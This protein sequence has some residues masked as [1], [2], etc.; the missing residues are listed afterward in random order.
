[1]RGPCP[2]RSSRWPGTTSSTCPNSTRTSCRAGTSALSTWAPT[3][4]PSQRPVVAASPSD[5][6]RPAGR[7]P[8]PRPARAAWRGRALSVGLGLL[9]GLAVVW[10][11]AYFVL[12]VTPAFILGLVRAAAAPPHA[13]ADVTAPPGVRVTAWATGLSNPTSL[14]FGPD[15]RLY[16]AELAG[17]VLALADRDGDGSAETRVTFATG[18]AS[19]LGLAFYG[20]DLY[21]GRRG[22]VTRLSDTN[23]DGVADQSVT[24]IGGLP[25]LRHQTDGLAFGP[26]GRLYIGQ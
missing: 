4:S 12:G 2:R 18:L 20:S 15:G 21:V 11:L 6:E 3:C 24:V 17:Q 23:G 8:T 1:M 10:L 14:T 16:V 22:G 26:D 7:P 13:P 5:A 25:A 19:P 9:V